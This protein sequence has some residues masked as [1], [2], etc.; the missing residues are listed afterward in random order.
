MADRSEQRKDDKAQTSRVLK[1]TLHQQ[2]RML[3]GRRRELLQAKRGRGEPLNKRG[4]PGGWGIES[5]FNDRR[6][7]RF[8]GGGGG[9]GGGGMYP[10]PLGGRAGYGGAGGK[11]SSLQ[12]NVLHV[13]LSFHISLDTSRAV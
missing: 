12:D 11:T 3:D 7:G 4:P 5:R 8:G 6:G 9:G 13:V 2:Q 1:R 10:P